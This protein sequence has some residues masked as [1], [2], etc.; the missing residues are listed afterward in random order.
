MDA[1]RI[2][3]PS[4]RAMVPRPLPRAPRPRCALLA[5]RRSSAV[6]SAAA[7]RDPYEVLGLP[8]TATM[9]DVK[10]AYRKKALKLHPDVNKAPDARERFMEA[11]N[12]YQEIVDREKRGSRGSNTDSSA[13]GGRTGGWGA[14][15]ASSGFGRSSAGTGRGTSSQPEE[16]YGLGR[17]CIR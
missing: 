15:S 14:S 13:S 5:A 1:L 10:K 7:R 4:L 11:K 3:A 6:V 8:R 2:T 16:F 9:A 17:C 12:A